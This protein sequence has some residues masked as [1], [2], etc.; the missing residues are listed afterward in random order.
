MPREHP[1]TPGPALRVPAERDLGLVELH[2]RSGL[3]VVFTRDGGLFALRHDGSLINQV[4]PSPGDAGLFRL[5]LREHGVAGGGG[6]GVPLA[7]PAALFQPADTPGRVTWRARTGSGL[8]C[9]TT[10]RLHPDRPVWAWQVRLHHRGTAPVQC[11]LVVAHDLGLADEG[12]VRNNEAYTS[13]YIDLLPIEDPALGWVVLARQN[14]PAA[15]GRHPWL[16][17][18]C[19]DGASAFATDGWQFFGTDH[20]LTGVAA[21]ETATHLPSRRLQ[22]ECAMAALQSQLVALAPG[23]RLTITFVGCFEPDHPGASSPDDVERLRA[24]LSGASF[25]A[26]AAELPAAEGDA[27]GPP[28][29]PL[30]ATTPW[31]HGEEPGPEDWQRWFPGPRR[32][33]QTDTDGRLLSFFHGVQTH[34]VARAKEAMVARPH[35]HILRSGDASWIDD[36]QFG[37][38]WRAC[39]PRRRISATRALPGCSRSCATRW[40]PR[41]RA[42]SGCLSGGRVPGGNWASPAPSP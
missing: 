28:G 40:E 15:G 18:A 32:H 37:I 13:H 16:A 27:S 24:D 9:D 19:A 4:L 36:T 41:A 35:G 21:A 26:G 12:A 8:R 22:Y 33:D 30:F 2:N 42:G 20:R 25:G 29:G 3:R 17:L 7:G 34:V 11:D 39:L 14:Q 6:R 38:T 10:F 1:T 5:L 23:E 31:L